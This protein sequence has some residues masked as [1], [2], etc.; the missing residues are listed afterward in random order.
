[1]NGLLGLAAFAV[2]GLSLFVTSSGEA[3]L[4]R[5]LTSARENYLT[6]DHYASMFDEVTIGSEN[7]V[8]CFSL[9]IEHGEG[10]EGSPE[11]VAIVCLK[12]SEVTNKTCIKFMYRT[13]D[14]YIMTRLFAGASS[15]CNEKKQYPFQKA[16]RVDAED[17]VKQ[18]T[19]IVCLDSFDT[20]PG[21]DDTG[22]CN[23]EIC[24]AAK[25]EVAKID[26]S[27]LITDFAF[28]SE[29]NSACITNGFFRRCTVDLL[30]SQNCDIDTA[31]F[32]FAVDI[33]QSLWDPVIGGSAEAFQSEIDF[34]VMGIEA[35][36]NNGGFNLEYGVATFG[37]DGEIIA[38]LTTAANASE[39]VSEVT[40]PTV[41][42]GTNVEDALSAC[43]TV[44][45]SSPKEFRVLILITDGVPTV[46]NTSN[47]DLVSQSD[48]IKASGIQ[49]VTIGAGQFI[50]TGL[51]NGL[52]TSGS[53][54][55]VD[56][57]MEFTSALD[58][59]LEEVCERSLSVPA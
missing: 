17:K 5:K 32:C 26:G 3:V 11:K 55:S 47:A 39:A 12:I 56:S 24:V 46:G 15:N 27:H 25:L 38:D 10:W 50:D 31:A 22:C 44:L 51:L 2:V 6:C 45:N 54:I 8:K 16:M 14:D 36:E 52:S 7:N 49:I 33:S 13:V 9:F 4:D 21:P 34:V 28:P 57:I 23:S 41:K 1:M 40:V 48:S 18:K 59:L 37:D 53:L 43:E 29:S 58:A 30:C 20:P 19:L 35:I 42:F